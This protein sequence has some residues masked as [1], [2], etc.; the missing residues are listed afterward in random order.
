MNLLYYFVKVEKL[1]LSTLQI[2]IKY[3]YSYNNMNIEIFIKIF[4]TGM[5]KIK[6]YA[7]IIFIYIK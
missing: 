7:K 6:V 5:R 1:L 4:F 2:C 3:S